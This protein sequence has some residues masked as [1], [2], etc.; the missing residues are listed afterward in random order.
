MYLLS[1]KLETKVIRRRYVVSV[2]R[3]KAK[4][5]KEAFSEIPDDAW[6]VE[7]DSQDGV[8]ILIFEQEQQAKLDE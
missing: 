6:L 1:E 8:T 3:A 5:Y 7:E 4:D 2:R